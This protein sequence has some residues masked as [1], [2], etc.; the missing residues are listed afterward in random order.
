MR[1]ISEGIG[2]RFIAPQ[3]VLQ[4]FLHFDPQNFDHNVIVRL[5]LPRLAAAL[6]PVLLLELLVLCCRLS[7]VTHWGATYFRL[8]CRSRSC[9]RCC[10]CA[11]AGLSGWTPTAG[12]YGRRVI[13][14]VDIA[15]FLRR[16]F[17]VNANESYF[18][19]RG[20]IGVRVLN[21]GCNPDS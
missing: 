15:A 16:A 14:P 8:K 21:N 13:V 12:I 6:L 3:T 4:A 9:C 1:G 10:Q 18:M 17:R 11:W 19:R 2:A 20:A 7:F 5:R